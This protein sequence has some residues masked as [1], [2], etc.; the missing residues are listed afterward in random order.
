[1]SSVETLTIL[2]TRAAAQLRAR[3]ATLGKILFGTWLNCAITLVCVTLIS[4][5]AW[6]FYVWFWRDAVFTGTSTDCRAATGACW[7][8]VRAKVEFAIYGVY[9]AEERWRAALA[10]LI[11]AAMIGFTLIPRFWSVRLVPAWIGA[12]ALAFLTLRGGLAG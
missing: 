5:L 6:H 12:L 2:P 4:W 9:P 1:M 3:V 7:A 8:F 10:I 11:F